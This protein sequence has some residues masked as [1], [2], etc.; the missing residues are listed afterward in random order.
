M[1]SV[2]LCLMVSKTEGSPQVIKEAMAC[3]CPIVSADVGDVKE[4]IGKTEGC[5]VCFYDPGDVA[6]KLKMALDYRKIHESTQG[7]NRIIELGLDS[8]TIAKRII[9]IYGSVL[10]RK[11]S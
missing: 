7:R 1:N 3:N 2:D 10:R 4:V 8:E 6:E 5:F 11:V 9:S